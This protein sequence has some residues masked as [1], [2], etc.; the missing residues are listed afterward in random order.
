MAAATIDI[1]ELLEVRDGFRQGRPLIRGTGI[2]V[3]TIAA[4]YSSGLTPQE[5]LHDFPQ[6]TMAGVLAAL[7]YYEKHR[8]D[9]VADLDRD[10]AAALQAARDLG[11]EVL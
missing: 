3:H 1:N 2:T 10:E 7:T 4:C 5:I 8:L 9:V 11:A 6:L